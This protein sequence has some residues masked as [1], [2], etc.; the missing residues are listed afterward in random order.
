MDFISLLGIRPGLICLTGSGGKTS[1]AHALAERLDGRVV[2]CTTTRIFPSSVLPVFTGD[3]VGELDR[4][5]EER[6]AVCVGTP[7]ENG[8]LTT[9]RIDFDVLRELADYVL[10]EADGSRGMPLKAHLAHEPVLPAGFDR[11]LLLVGAEGFGKTVLQTVHRAERF[12]ELAGCTVGD[13]ASPE[14]VAIVLAKEG[15]FDA[16]IVNQV[17]RLER[18]ER[19]KR[20]SD[21]LTAPVFAGEVRRGTL[22]P[23]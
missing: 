23:L 1:L 20:I 13:D 12:A 19:A 9:P 2:F 10:V 11:N 8:K 14:N 6:G 15:R 22:I 16:V 7:A 17:D 3:G 4:L 21:C 5:L 18:L